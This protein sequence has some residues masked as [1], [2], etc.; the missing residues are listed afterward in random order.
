MKLVKENTVRVQDV[1]CGE[2]SF[3]ARFDQVQN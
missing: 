2:T 3:S 1:P